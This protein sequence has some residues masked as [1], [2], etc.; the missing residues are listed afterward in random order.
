MTSGIKV[1]TDNGS[2]LLSSD[3]EPFCFYGKAYYSSS[4]GGNTYNF[5]ST[6]PSYPLVFLWIP[7]GNS[8]SVLKIDGSGGNWNIHILSTTT[9]LE[10]YVFNKASNV[11]GSSS[12]GIKMF[13]Q[14][15]GET[16]NSGKKPLV[17][18]DNINAIPDSTYNFTWCAKPIFAHFPFAI[19]E[20]ESSQWKHYDWSYTY[21]QCDQVQNCVWNTY[22]RNDYVCNTVQQCGYVQ[23]YQWVCNY[24]FNGSYVCSNQPTWVYQCQSVQQCNWVQTPYQQYDCTWS[25]YCY[26][27]IGW[28]TMWWRQVDWYVYRETLQPNSN[29][30]FSTSWV[31]NA[32]GNYN[33]DISYQTNDPMGWKAPGSTAPVSSVYNY[34]SATSTSPYANTGINYN[35]YLCLISDGAIYD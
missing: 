32:Y 22:Y 34:L 16:Y 9:S 14:Y 23:S 5:I 25:Q 24:D 4:E 15:G 28:S 21:T 26:Q 8:A 13:N 17:V 30:Q 27:K 2:V 35:S 12:Y 6:C 31:V 18:R 7:T 33:T 3:A 29:S 10:V 1:R 11:G 20:T 19:R